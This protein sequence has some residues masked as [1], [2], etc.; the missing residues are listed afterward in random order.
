MFVKRY[1]EHNENVTRYFAD[2]PEDL[3]TVCFETEADPWAPLCEFLERTAMPD[4]PFPWENR[5]PEA[6]P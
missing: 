1:N 5:D 4:V 2:R 6:G 3:L